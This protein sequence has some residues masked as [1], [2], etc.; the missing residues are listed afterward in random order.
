ML[1][2]R[3]G[4]EVVLK[5]QLPAFGIRELGRHVGAVEADAAG[6]GGEQGLARNGGFGV[7]VIHLHRKRD[8]G[9]GDVSVGKREAASLGDFPHVGGEPVEHGV[10]GDGGRGGSRSYPGF[11]ADEVF[12]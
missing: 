6:D 11:M 8:E 7:L 2:Q 1:F 9:A 3:E 4:V 5:I 10:G 12:K